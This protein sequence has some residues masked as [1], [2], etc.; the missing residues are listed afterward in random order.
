[1][2]DIFGTLGPACA[3]ADIL[4]VMLRRGMT[5]MRLNLSHSSLQDSAEMIGKFHL[6][7]KRAGKKAELLIDMQGPELR[8]GKVSHPYEIR[9]NETVILTCAEKENTIHIEKNVFSAAEEG[10]LIL[11]DDGRSRSRI[12]G[13]DCPNHSVVQVVGVPDKVFGGISEALARGQAASQ[14]LTLV[15]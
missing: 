3:N 4:E 12:A 5:G 2:I 8:I 13:E 9:E 7:A 1:M 15:L 14:N 6:A 11:I 10:D